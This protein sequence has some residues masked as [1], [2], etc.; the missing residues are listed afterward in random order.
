MLNKHR[1]FLTFVPQTLVFFFKHYQFLNNSSWIKLAYLPLY[2]HLQDFYT[3]LHHHKEHSSS[4][5]Y[6]SI[7]RGLVECVCQQKK[8]F[9]LQSLSLISAVKVPLKSW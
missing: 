8:G 5:M 2:I 4:F 6:S 7:I 9:I 1:A 3:H